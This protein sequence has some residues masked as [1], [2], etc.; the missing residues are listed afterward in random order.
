VSVSKLVAATAV[1]VLVAGLVGCTTGD[2]ANAPSASPTPSPSSTP[3]APTVLRLAVYGDRLRVETYHRIAEAY[4]RAHPEVT[5]KLRSYPDAA[6]ASAAGV[7]GLQNGTGPDVFLADQYSLPTLVDTGRL[8]P[9]DTLLEDR[10]LQFGDD[11]Q[12][13][14]LSSFSA[15]NRLQCMPAEMSPLVVYVNTQ[16]VRRHQLTS[17]QISFPTVKQP[18]WGWSDF[19]TIAQLAASSDL[20]GPVKGASVPVS[21]ETLTAFVRSAGGEVVDDL[22]APTSLDLASD[23]AISALTQ[24]LTLERDPAVAPTPEE[25]RHRDAVSWFTANE[26]GMFVGTRDDLPRLRATAGLRFDVWPLPSLGRPRTVARVDGYCID[27]GSPS[28]GVA[29][30]F[31]AFAVG[32]RGSA[33][34]ASSGVI[35]PARV[36]TLH[37]PVFLERGLPPPSSELYATSLRR[38]EPMPYSA[39]WPAVERVADR[40]FARLVEDP[41]TDLTTGL[42]EAMTRL[43][44][45]STRTFARGTTPDGG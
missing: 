11:Y 6:T 20:L 25:L 45:V 10:G 1:L 8:Q 43:D 3:P 22:L 4:M 36:A 23:D 29:S 44:R 2:R 32:A 38:A 35:V 31:V 13:T 28:I 24:V 9:V 12:R 5:I 39:Q 7:R 27:A 33:I 37:R 16:L 17:D 18:S 21:L 26:L 30:D 19:V 42:Q 41:Q 40:R 34:A 15:H 14:A